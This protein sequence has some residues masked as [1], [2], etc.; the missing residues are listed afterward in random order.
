MS[1]LGGADGDVDATLGDFRLRLAAL[2]RPPRATPVLVGVNVLVFAVMAAAGA[3]ILRPD[4]AVHIRFGSNLGPLTLDGEW[5]RLATAVFIHFGIL[6]LAFNM[7]ALWDAGRLVERLYGTAR[8]VLVYAVAGLAGSIASLAWNPAV[9]SAGA[10]GAIFGVFGALLAFL[11]DSRNGVPHLLLVQLRRNALV[12]IV[13]AI[14]FGFVYPGI[15][16]AAHL[17]GLAAG[18]LM[19]ALL[20]RPLTP[21]ARSRSSWP[22]LLLA[23][24]AGALA[25]ALAVQWLASP[26]PERAAELQLRR[27]LEWFTETEARAIGLTR[28]LAGEAQ[29]GTLDDRG[30]AMRMERDVLPLWEQLAA[31]VGRGY[32]LAPDSPLAAVPGLLGAYT[33]RRLESARLFVTAARDQDVAS[34]ERASE[35]AR[36][37]DELGGRL[38]EA[39]ARSR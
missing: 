19:G 34:L 37:A 15:D 9:N 22:Q 25:L 2:T 31:R 27:D 18:V 24:A 29:A 35:S 30:F 5:W 3:G 14:G 17:G 32:A 7:W 12:F 26:S 13:L 21:P 28:S 8:F 23:A 6:H 33:D 39:L 38:R 1:A 20:A 10:S 16:N 36:Q 11:L 4:A